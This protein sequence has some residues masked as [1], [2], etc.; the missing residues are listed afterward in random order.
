MQFLTGV[1]RKFLTFSATFNMFTGN[2][3]ISII[4]YRENR[5]LGFLYR[6][7]D[8]FLVSIPMNLIF[9]YILARFIRAQSWNLLSFG[10]FG[11]N[12]GKKRSNSAKI[13]IYENPALIPFAWNF[14]VNML[15]IIL[16]ANIDVN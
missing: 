13:S 15:L 1:S 6:G 11:I 8:N 3:L 16:F 9:F 12:E 5:F 10:I 14:F 7:I 2:I 4:L